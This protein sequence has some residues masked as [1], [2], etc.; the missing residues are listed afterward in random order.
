M[1]LC[2]FTRLGLLGLYVSLYVLTSLYVL[3]LL[4]P[5]PCVYT[6]TTVTLLTTDSLPTLSIPA[7]HPC[8]HTHK[9]A[10]LA[11]A[12]AQGDQGADESSVAPSAQGERKQWEYI[13]VDGL[14][15]LP[16]LVCPH[17]DKACVCVCVCVCVCEKSRGH[18]S[19]NHV[20]DHV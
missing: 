3:A 10:M 2:M 20:S 6:L 8:T 7:P 16:G 18:Q 11:A 15:L 9:A 4:T 5:H 19:C 17:H 1:S 14:G 13:R 12:A